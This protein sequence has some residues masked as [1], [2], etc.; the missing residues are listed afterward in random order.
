MPSRRQDFDMIFLLAYPSKARQI[1]PA[2][3]YYYAGDIPVFAT[4]SVYSGHANI[5]KDKDLNGII[6]CDLP[7]VFSHQMSVK[8]WPEQFNSYNR[9]YALGRESYALTTQINQLLL[10]PLNKSN[11]SLKENQQITHLLEWGQFKEGKVYSLNKT[12]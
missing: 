12:V 5:L 1:M 6:F 4:S 3:N 10:F 8:N 2:L 7:W 9:L 11:F